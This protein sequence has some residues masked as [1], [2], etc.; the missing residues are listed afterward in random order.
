MADQ[1][2]VRATD[3][4]APETPEQQEAQAEDNEVADETSEQPP[5]E[6]RAAV[7]TGIGGRL[8]YVKVL[9]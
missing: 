3:E 6:M 8:Q 7:L 9:K 5:T 2:Q 1:Q 4:K